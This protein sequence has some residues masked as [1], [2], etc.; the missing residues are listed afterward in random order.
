MTRRA[1]GLLPDGTG[2][3]EITLRA[4]GIEAR[5]ITWGAVLRD[6]VVLRGSETPRHVVLGL[7]SIED[8]LTY[9][10]NFGAICGRVANRIARG[11]MTIDGRDHA[12]T[13]NV[14]G[15]HTLHGGTTGFSRRVWTVGEADTASVTL[16]HVSPS[17]EE[18]FPGTV[19]AHC[20]YRLEAPATLRIVLTATT[21]APTALNL[22]PHPYFN[23][24]GSASIDAHRLTVAADFHTPTDDEGIPTG[25]IRMVAGTGYDFRSARA[26][27][28]AAR[29]AKGYDG[30]LVLR[31][32]G[33]APGLLPVA[34]LASP[35]GD[36][37][38]Q[39]Q[40]TEPGLQLYDAP[41]LDLPV[42]GV[43]GRRY[44]P[45]AGLAIEP[46]RFPDAPNHAHFPSVI[47]RPGEIS[48]QESLFVFT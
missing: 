47:L 13:T 29:P 3:D 35:G 25:E 32:G 10:R 44:G 36:L 15:R 30:N 41:T 1:F 43:D 40:T 46:Q 48:R 12:L 27:G 23:L 11:R 45:R 24:D 17:G 42:A 18:G 19:R 39:V 22:A 38:M 7:N 28:D 26:L 34:T 8:Y 6:L 16:E 9:S 5:V 2:V 33:A 4:P 14:L 20:V 21:D 37:T 31:R